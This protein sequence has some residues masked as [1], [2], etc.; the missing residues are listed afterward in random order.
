[1]LESSA[2]SGYTSP[3]AQT[4]T[5]NAGDSRNYSFLYTPQTPGLL[6]VRITP[7]NAQWRVDGGA[8]NVSGATVGSLSAGSHALEF[9][10]A[11]GYLTP[12]PTTV[13]VSPTETTRLNWTYDPAIASLQM[14]LTPS[15]ARWRVNGGTWLTIAGGVSGNVNSPWFIEYEPVAGYST[16]HAEYLRLPANPNYVTLTRTYQ[17]TTTASVSIAL[18]LEQGQWRIYS[19]STPSGSWK[20]GTATVAG[21]AAGSYTIEYAGRGSRSVYQVGVRAKMTGVS[22]YILGIKDR[23]YLPTTY[24]DRIGKASVTGYCIRFRSLAGVNIE[25]LE[26]AIRDGVGI[27]S[28]NQA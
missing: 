24:G 26:A 9:S 3:L 13:L 7:G 2:E 21:L 16:P 1:V 11:P 4:V 27:T 5:L 15:N 14:A 23:T 12:S 19:G 10:S 28:R 17:P 18:N 25:V 20:T 8:W 6:N 22:V